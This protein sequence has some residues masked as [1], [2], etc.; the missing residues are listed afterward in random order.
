MSFNHAEAQRRY[1]AKLKERAKAACGDVCRCGSK[2][3]E[4]AHVKPTGLN[5]CG[6]GMTHRFL[7]V[8]KH[9]KHYRPMCKSCHREHDRKKWERE[10]K[11]YGDEVP[12]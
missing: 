6:R 8:I 3:V 9:P 4:F 7:D 2:E 5:G 12:F 10:R 11:R 1:R